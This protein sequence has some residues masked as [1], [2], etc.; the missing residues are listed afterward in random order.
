MK[1]KYFDV[2]LPLPLAQSFTYQYPDDWNVEVKIGARVI[3]PFGTKKYYTGL[4]IALNIEPSSDFHIKE[5]ISLLDINPIV[6]DY[7]LK[8][9]SW[10]S[11]YYLCPIG[12]VYKA[13]LPKGLKLESESIIEFN[14]DYVAHKQ[15]LKEKLFL[16]VLYNE[17]KCTIQ[18]IAKI[19]DIKNPLFVVNSLFNK[20]AIKIY[21]SLRNGYKPK[22]ES[23]IRISSSYRSDSSLQ[24]LMF[25]LSHAKKQ[26]HFILRLLDLIER[27]EKK[28]SLFLEKKVLL[29]REYKFGQG[30]RSLEI[31]REAIL[32][33]LDCSVFVLSALI[34]R[35][36]LE[37]VQH[38][39]IET[40]ESVR[41]Q[42]LK[43]LSVSQQESLD[44]IKFQFKNKV[45][46][47]LHGVTSSGKT[48]I[49][50]KLIH[51][52]LDRGEQVLYLLPEI[53]LT[54]QITTR[55]QCVFGNRFGVYHSKF[56]DKKRVEI[57]NKQL[58]D[59]PYEVILGVRSSLFLPFKKL[60][61]IIVDEE[62]DSSYK[63]VSPSPRYQARDTAIYLANQIGANVLLGSAT[64]SVESYYN[65]VIG[66][67][68][69][70]NLT[71]RYQDIEM[72][73]VTI[74]D[75]RELRRKKQMTGLF[76]PEL[77]S[78]IDD[79]LAK[80]EQVI[81]FKNRRGYSPNVMCSICGWI[82]TC[83][84]CDVSM[85][86]HR[87]N[88]R[89]TCHYCGY[90][91]DKPT[92]CPNC[93]SKEIEPMGFGTE[94]LEQ[95]LNEKIPMAKSVRM[96]LDTTRSKNSYERII[97]S[98]ESGD[99]NVLI[100]T[101]MVTKGLDFDRVKIVGIIHADLM[102]NYPDF[103]SHERAFQLMSQVAGRAGRKGG[104]GFVIIQTNNPQENV[105][106]QVQNHDYLGMYYAE[107]K[108]RE[109]WNYPPFS[110]IIKV[111]LKHRNSQLL[112]QQARWVGEQL[113]NYLGSRVLGPQ[114]PPISKVNTFYIQQ[115]LIKVEL[116]LS[117]KKIRNILLYIQRKLVQSNSGR[118]IKIYFDVDPS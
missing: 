111:I 89:L 31:R 73:R 9:W 91:I 80:N 41:K 48:E 45:A 24:K 6:Y 15:S 88:N 14:I 84:H 61:L 32:K 107:I 56:S 106:K 33:K 92:E 17:K 4:V 78:T 71:T 3:V 27:I 29:P 30:E 95:V 28:D 116:N 22:L 85:T 49:Y 26:E 82:P 54:A 109:M 1:T 83:I 100:G 96:D 110:H 102:L 42:D 70:V 68:G 36:V 101:Q 12:D 43:L 118:A 104:N 79:A 81:L 93:G 117:V 64:P 74:I 20:G 66:K 99:K 75:T 7:Q 8:L 50:L 63:Q 76:A 52:A 114:V 5:A 105:F 90:S 38:K 39:Y 55:I 62:H 67:Y 37:I 34:K 2:I 11:F 44:A 113:Q 40:L 18:H 108:E 10:I 87:F 13:A 94:R 59:N 77:L 16:D 60:G 58:S 53:A 112:D 103:R 115:L 69:L 35:G 46:V 65:A 57:W 21:E 25:L 72:P 97:S 98:F 86:Y 51:D 23:W 19:V 47:L